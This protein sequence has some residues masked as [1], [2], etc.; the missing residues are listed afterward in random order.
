MVKKSR[1]TRHL[2]RR[3]PSSTESDGSESE[4]RKPAKK[5]KLPDFENLALPENPGVLSVTNN[6]SSQKTAKTSIGGSA[7]L[8]ESHPKQVVE[9]HGKQIGLTSTTCSSK[10][11]DDP[12][13]TALQLK[14]YLKG[15]NE[16][17]MQSL[18][19]SFQGKDICHY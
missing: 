4:K 17:K 5:M 2:K 6:D 14:P 3:I 8:K 1:H 19:K 11:I 16:P 9:R 15:I 7:P 10:G 12:L 18:P 13:F